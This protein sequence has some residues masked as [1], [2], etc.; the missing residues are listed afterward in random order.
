MHQCHG[1]SAGG[2]VC[3]WASGRWAYS[4][5][6][7][8]SENPAASYLDTTLTAEVT[9]GTNV[10]TGK[11][12]AGEANVDDATVKLFKGDAE[13]AT[14]TATTENGAFTF[15][16]LEAGT[17]KVTVTEVP[18]GYN[19]PDEATID[20]LVVEELVPTE[21]AA[22]TYSLVGDGSVD[23]TLPEGVTIKEVQ[24]CKSD[25]TTFTAIGTTYY[26]L[27]DK[28]AY[29][30]TLTLNGFAETYATCNSIKIL[31][32]GTDDIITITYSATEE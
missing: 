8:G 4:A 21:V 5:V 3:Q 23:I 30:K 29:T 24:R 16:D 17:Y 26:S 28:D 15:A 27:T 9:E 6:Q 22:S 20:S 12:L 18:D 25:G 13:E 7:A 32:N 11:V 1:D 2:S 10:I 14:A 31:F 19:L